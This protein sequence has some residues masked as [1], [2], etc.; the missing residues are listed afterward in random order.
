MPDWFAHATAYGMQAALLFWACLPS[1]RRGRALV[2]GVLGAS[3]F[4]M[5][6]EALQ[7]FQPGRTVELKDIAAN[8]VGALLV[9]SAIAVVGRFGNRRGG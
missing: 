1:L 5:M 4:G 6:T 7:R 3:V 9:G 8:C 2:I